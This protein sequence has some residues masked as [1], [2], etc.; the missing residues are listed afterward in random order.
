M[1]QVIQIVPNLP[2]SVNG[3]GDYS[4]LLAKALRDRHGVETLFLVANA[5]W[6]GGAEVEG[7]PVRRLDA[8]RAVIPFENA[9][10][11]PVLLHYVGYGYSRRGAPVWLV[12]WL[13][14][15]LRKPLPRRFYTFFHE[16]YAVGPPW[17]SSFWLSPVQR[18]VCR[19]FA[20][21]SIIRLTN[22]TDS[23]ENL[24]AMVSAP[25]SSTQVH[26]LISH[27]GE[28]ETLPPL[29]QR[30]PQL[31]AYG[32]VSRLPEDRM[33]AAGKLRLF[34]EKLGLRK[35]VTFGKAGWQHLGGGI[36]V[37]NRG[38]LSVPQISALLLESQAAY[39]DYPKSC[40]GK[41][42]IFS[43]YCAHGLLPVLLRSDC[44]DAEGLVAGEHLAVADDPMTAG[45]SSKR[46]QI[47]TKAHLWYQGHSISMLA[48]AVHQAL[49]TER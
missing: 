18:W 44:R 37:E 19:Q 2:P 28:P 14:V 47:A 43:S 27:F 32:G 10:D 41:S 49:L 30:S 6:Y 24:R 8:K 48:K 46:Q 25:A 15:A 45:D 33:F 11:A 20:R 12:N 17:K 38:L 34:C 21:E 40:L 26:Q 35:V 7:F 42:S 3:V 9:D 31:A 23:A 22:R 13:R 36:V 4:T 29:S 39:V 1:T 16:L 5:A